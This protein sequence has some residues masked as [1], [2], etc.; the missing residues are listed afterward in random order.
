MKPDK[1]SQRSAGLICDGLLRCLKRKSFT[2]ITITDIQREAG[3]GRATFYRLFDNIHDVL[4]YLCDT[5]F[6]EQLFSQRPAYDQSLEE[7]FLS[8]IRYWM[9]RQEVLDA[10]IS[11]NRMDIVNNV[12]RK[13]A[14]SVQ[15]LYPQLS[16]QPEQMA[17]ICGM[18]TSLMVSVLQTWVEHG[19]RETPEEILEYVSVIPKLFGKE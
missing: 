7:L 11:C 18:V 13:N 8:G 14:E 4:V 5:T 1:R 16:I 19:K 9:E 10:I 2:Q 17:Y 6:G 12:F 15:T 3:V